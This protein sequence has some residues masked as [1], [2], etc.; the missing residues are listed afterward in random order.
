[1]IITLY[2]NDDN[3]RFRAPPPLEGPVRKRHSFLSRFSC[4]C[5]EPV[6]VKM[7]IMFSIHKMGSPKMAFFPYLLCR[8][9]SGEVDK[10]IRHLRVRGEG[11]NT[12]LCGFFG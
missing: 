10:H 8:V 3:E 9:G 7:M 2:D 1:M 12:M 11:R 5:P 6:L 4:V